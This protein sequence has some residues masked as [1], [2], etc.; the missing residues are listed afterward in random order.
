MSEYTE[1]Y[2]LNKRVKIFQPR[3][4]YRA[5][6]DA[7]FLSAMVNAEKLKGGEKILDVGSGTGAVSLCLAYR[8]A[9]KKVQITGLDIQQDLVELSNR[10]AVANGFASFLIYQNVDIRKKI[11]LDSASFDI[12]ITN[13]PYS[14]HDMPSPK[15]G[16]QIAHNLQNFDLTEWLRFCLKILCPKGKIFLINRVEALNEILSV[17]HNRAG[18]IRILPLYSKHGQNAKRIIVSGKK[19]SR[20][21]TKILPPLYTHNEDGSYTREAEKILRQA[22]NIFAE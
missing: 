12:V 16:K 6:I 22:Q 8:L 20:G 11:C 21:I 9:T 5:S 17:M 3:D 1:D 2:L 13:P 4:G 14:D 15:P 18:D 10:S 19:G 7:V